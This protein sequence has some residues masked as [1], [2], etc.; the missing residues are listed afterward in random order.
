[1]KGGSFK[2]ANN[3]KDIVFYNLNSIEVSHKEKGIIDGV[4]VG[5]YFSY[6]ST[7]FF[8]RGKDKIFIKLIG[9]PPILSFDKEK[10]SFGFDTTKNYVN[11]ISL[12]Y[13]GYLNKIII[14]FDDYF[15]I[16]VR[17]NDKVKELQPIHL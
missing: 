8:K 3:I 16:S 7:F 11:S 9:S 10:S 5:E 1:M 4:Y 14:S 12:E 2:M 13:T 6:V 15:S 17:F